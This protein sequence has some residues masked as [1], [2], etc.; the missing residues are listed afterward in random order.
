MSCLAV[1][2]M[3]QQGIRPVKGL[4]QSTRRDVTT[5]ALGGLRS[6]GRMRY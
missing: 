4:M 1:W 5:V 6:E 3:D 2:K